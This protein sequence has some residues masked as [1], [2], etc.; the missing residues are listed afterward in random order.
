MTN[1]FSFATACFLVFGSLHAA[2]VAAATPDAPPAMPAL[3][4]GVTPEAMQA[5]M[6][7]MA[8]GPR[9]AELAKQVGEWDTECEQFMPGMPVQKTKG[10][11]TITLI[12]NGRF[13]HEEFKGTMMGQPFEGLMLLGY[14]N[15]LKRYDSMWID[16]MGTGM[17]VSHG[18]G[19]DPSELAGSFYC[20]MAGKEISARLVTK[21][22]NDDK[23]IFEMHA[24]GPDG[25]ES[26][27][28]RIT[29][30]RRK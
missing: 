30:N 22:V 18:K 8:P 6:A 5:M 11:A 17:M 13:L 25:K 27:M 20:P 28:M 7:S 29:Y 21:I 26:L 12:M 2:E 19:D 9:H 15:N 1:F 14:D 10:S 23:H 3:P 24:P 4:P 16:S